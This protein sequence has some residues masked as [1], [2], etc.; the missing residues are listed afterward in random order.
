MADRTLT[1][2]LLAG[3][4]SLAL[5]AALLLGTAL[6]PLGLAGAL[7]AALLV[8][9]VPAMRRLAVRCPADTPAAGDRARDLTAAREFVARYGED[10]LAPFILRPDKAFA[11]AAGGVLGYRVLGRTAVI[12]GDPVAPAGRAGEVLGHFAAQARGRGL[13]IAIYGA[14]PAHLDAYRA[15]GLRVLQVGEEAVA[16]PARFTLEG[17]AVRKLRQS[18]HRIARRGY[19]IT[20]A[21]GGAIETA[22]E[23]EIDALEAA[24]RAGQSRVLG[25][26][27]SFGAYEGSVAASDLYLLARD[28]DGRLV[29]TMRFIAHRGK[30]SLATMRRL[31][32]T[33]NGLNEA[34]VC[35]ALEV[36]RERAIP[37]VS[38]NYAGLAHLIRRAPSGGWLRR[39][40]IAAT[41]ALLSRRFQMQRLVRFNEKFSLEWRPR[42]LV[43]SS[44]RALPV[45]VC[46]VLQAEGYLP[47]RRRV[48]RPRR[49]RRPWR[50][51][52]RV[53][54]PTVLAR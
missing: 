34:L 4:L 37:E 14:G 6:M 16:T 20:A 47:E 19:T 32:D 38:L 46:R 13:D 29:A 23:I 26:A 39:R 54:V 7:G 44:R 2:R 21:D 22:T 45:T 51:G 40:A 42:Y 15:M 43:Y 18:V 48:R 1:H 53:A 41:V 35:R 30:L 17:R 36:A 28:P 31:P 25:F 50:A 27:M 5:V 49:G 24:W 11:F 9:G 10:S 8:A 52:E 12:S 3:V 33:P